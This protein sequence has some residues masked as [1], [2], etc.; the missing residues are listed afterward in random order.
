M[1]FSTKS[2]VMKIV[3]TGILSFV[4]GIEHNLIIL[5]YDIFSFSF[6]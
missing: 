2:M 3:T 4:N 5:K 6:I 1:I